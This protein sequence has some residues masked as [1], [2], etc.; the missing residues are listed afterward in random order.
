MCG[1]YNRWA[2]RYKQRTARK[3]V[4]ANNPFRAVLMYCYNITL[5]YSY[6]YNIIMM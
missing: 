6:C 5:M 3:G 2:A 1:F 4:V